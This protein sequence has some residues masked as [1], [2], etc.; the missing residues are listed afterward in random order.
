MWRVSRRSHSTKHPKEK[1]FKKHRKRST[2]RN[3]ALH[4][5]KTV[6]WFCFEKNRGGADQAPESFIKDSTSVSLKKFDF[7]CRSSTSRH[8][9]LFVH[10]GPVIRSKEPRSYVTI[11][12]NFL[13]Y[14]RIFPSGKT[15]SCPDVQI[16]FKKLYRYRSHAK[17]IFGCSQEPEYLWYDQAMHFNRMFSLFL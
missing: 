6:Y 7:C 10:P 17:T 12:I 13:R 15:R 8:V 2:S 9:V 3:Q 1:K 5:W 14:F 16:S 4:D 11:C